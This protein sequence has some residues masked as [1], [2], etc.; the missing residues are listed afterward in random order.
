MRWKLLVFTAFIVIFSFLS[1]GEIK[2][3]GQDIKYPAQSAMMVSQYHGNKSKSEAFS[4]LQKVALSENIII[5]KTIWTQNGLEKSFVFG[6]ISSSD[7][8]RGY[9]SDPK[10]LN[11]EILTGMYYVASPW[12]NK[13]ETSMKNLGFII[14]GASIPLQLLPLDFYFGNLR[15]LAI[16]CLFFVFAVLLY[17]LKISAIK[18]SIIER[19]LGNFSKSLRKNLLIESSLLILASILSLLVFWI[20]NQ[21]TWGLFCRLFSYLILINLFIFLI[22]TLII[23]WIYSLNIRLIRPSDVLKSKSNQTV[24]NLIWL[25]GIILSVFIFGK[26]ISG[27]KQSAVELSQ[28][29]HQLHPWSLVQSFS[30]LTWRDE[31]SSHTNSSTHEIDRNFM[32]DYTKKE[33]DFILSFDDSQILY[34]YASSIDGGI[35]PKNIPPAIQEQLKSKGLDP[36]LASSVQFVSS[37]LIE[38]NKKIYPTNT[39]PKSSATALASIYIPQKFQKQIESIKHIAAAEISPQDLSNSNFEIIIIPDNQKTFLFH[40]QDEANQLLPKQSLQN[41]ILVVPHLTNIPDLPP[42]VSNIIGGALFDSPSL[43]KVLRQSPLQADVTAQN[44]ATEAILTHRNKI[45]N[46]LNGVIFSLVSLIIAQLFVLYEYIANQLRSQAKI[47][48]IHYILGKSILSPI[49]RSIFPLILG[50]SI[51]SLLTFLLTG[52]STVT[53]V[54][55]TLYCV[56]IG[57]L[58]QLGLKK[59]KRAYAQILKGDF[60]II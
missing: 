23:N 17:A 45:I 3:T 59:I 30:S 53:L 14:K 24:I 51:S 10:S 7:R 50:I 21:S 43:Q 41:Q 1:A 37:N 13:L 55:F 15:S 38:L 19:S 32:I 8:Q 44:Y 29:S 4:D 2:E 52:D 16:W 57:I 39:Y 26:T 58:T 27:M 49:S 40:W 34:S 33:K 6:K 11:T 28:Q 9:L 20:I 25:L 42:V 60:E 54:L 48:S 18:K 36:I 5:Y 31:E 56:E 35:D 12:T 22:L 46:Q 47:L